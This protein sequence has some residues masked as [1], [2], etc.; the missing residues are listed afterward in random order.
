[1]KLHYE[2]AS[3]RIVSWGTDDGIAESHL[4]GCAVLV[5]PDAD[6]DGNVITAN[7]GL[8][9]LTHKV[10]LTT[11]AAIALSNAELAAMNAPTMG[12]VARAVSQE[13]AASDQYMMPDH[14]ITADDRAKW[15]DY[16]RALRDCSKG[17][18]TAGQ[19]LALIPSRPD[20]PDGDDVFAVLRERE[21]AS[22]VQE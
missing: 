12:D 22:H 13:L 7:Q 16:R 1:M 19:M 14:P 4:P 11:R 21:A 10:D 6:E 17:V 8:S 9:G 15:I 5:I 20:G 18:E 2:T 3:G